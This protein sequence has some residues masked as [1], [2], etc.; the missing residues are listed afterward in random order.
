MKLI[1]AVVF[2]TSAAA[3]QTAVNNRELPVKALGAFMNVKSDGEHAYGY[4][5]E[6][7]K[8]G[9]QI[10]GLISAHDGLIGDPPAGLLENVRFN[11]QTRKLS[12]TAK[13]S[14]GIGVND[15]PTRDLFRFEGTLTAARLSGNLLV[16]DQQCAA[17]REKKKINLT[18]SKEWSR[19]MDAYKTYAEW[20]E[21]A[22]FI[23]DL[24]GPHW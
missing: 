21:Y 14:L 1:I 8:Q 9:A 23:L 4:D 12:F 2:L 15:Q 3:A 24:R 19:L 5:V 17:C 10:F 13:L 7:W 6:L 22:D 18:R 11:P 20:K 16:T